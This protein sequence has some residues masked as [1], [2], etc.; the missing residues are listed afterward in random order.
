MARKSN[1]SVSSLL[2]LLLLGGVGIYLLTK[3]GSTPAG[4]KPVAPI[5]PDGSGNLNTDLILQIQIALNNLLLSISTNPAYQGIP[6]PLSGQFDQPTADAYVRAGNI[7]FAAMQAAPASRE[8]LPTGTFTPDLT[9]AIARPADPTVTTQKA[10]KAFLAWLIMYYYSVPPAPP[11]A[12]ATFKS[13]A[14]QNFS[15][16]PDE[17]ALRDASQT[18]YA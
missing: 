8:V 4:G 9:I 1:P 7:V 15:M 10:S 2:P 11:R 12:F 16:H 17:K 6:E 13:Y 5:A 14:L 18:L 3:S